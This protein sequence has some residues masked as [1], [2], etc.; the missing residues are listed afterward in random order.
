[1]ATAQELFSEA[2]SRYLRPALSELGFK[3][4]SKTRWLRGS[5]SEGWIVVEVG[6]N[7]HNTAETGDWSVS[8]WAWPRGTWE[9]A[10]ARYQWSSAVPDSSLPPLYAAFE[11]VVSGDA[12]ER[13]D[14]VTIVRDMSDSAVGLA[15]QKL[16]EFT[17]LAVAWVEGV[18]ASDGA[19]E[20]TDAAH[21]LGSAE[22]TGN[23]TPSRIELLDE[24]TARAQRGA[25]R[26]GW[27]LL[28]Q[29]REVVGLEE[30]QF[31]AWHHQL[32]H[33]D[34]PIDRYPSPRDAF[35]HG[36]GSALAIQYPDGSSR[37]AVSEDFPDAKQLHRWRQAA[38][39]VPEHPVAQLPEWLPWS[40]W[41]L[42][43]DTS[44]RRST[45]WL[46]GLH[47]GKD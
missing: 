20:Y 8:V 15:A 41:V 40:E 9:W 34:G 43:E 27:D 12:R 30:V 28:A 24:L 11:R 25:W 10:S 39:T 36:H 33:L 14:T 38:N 45:R 31:P 29:W 7:R 32:M 37:A 1:M 5:P 2:R 42:R 13:A 18:L 3:V 35:A 17:R 44:E 16:V 19:D 21:V 6:G 47:R 4:N 46:T 22:V 26:P 23:W